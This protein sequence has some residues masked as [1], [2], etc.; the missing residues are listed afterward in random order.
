MSDK[1]IGTHTLSECQTIEQ[2]KVKGG[3][4]VSSE[5]KYLNSKSNIYTLS[6]SKYSL[7]YFSFLV[8][9]SPNDCFFYVSWLTVI[10]IEILGAVHM[11]PT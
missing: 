4:T 5:K 9:F 2:K 1:P 8:I 7:F 10:P 6:I 3:E 11:Y